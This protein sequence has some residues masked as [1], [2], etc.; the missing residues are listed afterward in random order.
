MNNIR[1]DFEIQWQHR[2][3]ALQR[4]DNGIPSDDTMLKMAAN[5]PTSYSRHKLRWLP[6]A[7]AACLMI[8]ITMFGISLH[9]A[10]TQLPVAE[11]V[12]I[13]GEKMKFLCNSGCSAQDIFISA[14]N[15]IN[16]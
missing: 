8:G 3:E 4:M 11:E 6:Y 16:Q 5:M 2:R 15:I 9:Q 7:A 10:K 12:I 1:N 14:R 13:K